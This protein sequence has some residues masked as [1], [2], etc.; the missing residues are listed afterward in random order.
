MKNNLIYLPGLLLI[1]F[2]CSNPEKGKVNEQDLPVVQTSHDT[3]QLNVTKVALTKDSIQVS[4]KIFNKADS[5]TYFIL[6][7]Y[8][9]PAEEKPLRNEV[10]LIDS[11]CA[12]LVYPTDEQL[13]SL[14]TEESENYATIVDDNT[15]YHGIAIEMLDSINVETINAEK[16]YLTFKT[17]KSKS[18]TLDIRKEGAPAWNLIFF[19]LRKEPEIISITDLSQER[20]IKYFDLKSGDDLSRAQS[21]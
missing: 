2:N 1:F 10:Q 4:P 8:F 11:T 19:S 18:W 12:V 9:A 14:Q 21:E 15:Y 3:V 7:N 17:G 20:I 6:S 16:R 5:Q 13:N